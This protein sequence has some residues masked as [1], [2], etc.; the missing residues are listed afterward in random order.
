MTLRAVYPEGDFHEK[1]LSV[2]ENKLWRMKNEQWKK[3]CPEAGYLYPRW[4]SH[5][6]LADGKNITEVSAGTY[7]IEVTCRGDLV[8][9][10]FMVI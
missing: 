10:S 6:V 9:S 3:S 4:R 2:I 7:E 5:S 8:L 1:S